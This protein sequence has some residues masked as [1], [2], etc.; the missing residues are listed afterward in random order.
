[1]YTVF[2][3]NDGAGKRLTYIHIYTA[4]HSWP[5]IWRERERDRERETE[6]ER[7]RELY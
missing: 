4:G 7:E 6:R 3:A 5:S 2:V 1:M